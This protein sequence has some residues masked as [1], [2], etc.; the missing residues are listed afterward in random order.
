LIL[1]ETGT[2]KELVARAIHNL[3]T[4][5]D[6]ALVKLNCAAVPSELLE[7]ELFG[8]VKGAY[9]GAVSQRMGRLELAHQGTLFL[10]EI[11]ELSIE[12]QPKL[13]RV[14]QDRQFEPLGGNRVIHSDFRLIAATNRNLEAMVADRRF[15]SDLFYR[16]SVFPIVVP[17]LRERRE[18]IP[19]LVS[20][21]V[22]KF[23]RKMGRKISSIPTEVMYS[24]TQKD[25]PGNIRELENFIER[26][27]ILSTGPEL[28]VGLDPLKKA[29]KP[30]P[31][32]SAPQKRPI[33][34][35]ED[36]E[37]LERERILKALVESN[38]IVSGPDGAAGR[39][40]FSPSTLLAQMQ[41]M[42]SLEDINPGPQ[43]IPEPRK[44]ESSGITIDAAGGR[45][46]EYDKLP[47]Y[48]VGRSASE[49]ATYSPDDLQA[50][51][52]EH[53][54]RILH[55][56]NWVI[57]GEKGAATRLGMKRTTLITRMAR[58][59]I[60]HNNLQHANTDSLTYG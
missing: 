56:T 60:S 52:R 15:R 55:E 1:G 49:H 24:L 38:G 32:T 14:L 25:W 57:G 34:I 46:D 42:A 36:S 59:G 4:R 26:A 47:N 9:T 41:H 31:E 39:L 18:D 11:G 20:H 37:T 19:V 58:L 29:V 27:V 12:L 28:K 43:L 10:D 13:L 8:H 21:F 2:G 6:S 22:R 7:S 17:P 33:P 44:S 3:S 30:L 45:Y 40:G 48:T 54:I 5:R 16:L 35:H 23:A 53:I 51:E 50:V